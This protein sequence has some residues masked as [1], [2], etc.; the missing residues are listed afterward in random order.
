[1]SS[2]TA[3]IDALLY[4]L[5]GMFIIG[6]GVGL[7]STSAE[8]CEPAT[9]ADVWG[10]PEEL[11]GPPGSQ[12]TRDYYQPNYCGPISLYMVLQHYG[13]KTSIEEVASL[14]GVERKG[15]SIA[16]LIRAAEAK[17]VSASAFR[18]SVRHLKR[19]QGPAIIDLPEGHYCVFA[20]W[21]DGAVLVLDP[22]RPNRWVTV[23]ELD[24]HWG[25]RLIVLAPNP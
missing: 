13:I 23:N 16:G 7:T 15:T 19:I 24:K 3:A 9:F 5:G 25:K 14:A 11:I 8:V 18:S 10:Q 22:P 4:C 1:M 12:Y 2:R 17:G 6:I 20:G 21:R